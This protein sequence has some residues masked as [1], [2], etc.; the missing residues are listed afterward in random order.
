M[1]EDF[2]LP[3]VF[4]YLVL[5]L[6]RTL[7]LPPVNSPRPLSLSLILSFS[8]LLALSFSFSSLHQL[9]TVTNEKRATAKPV[10][11]A[12]AAEAAAPFFAPAPQSG[13]TTRAPSSAQPRANKQPRTPPATTCGQV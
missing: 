6:T 8:Q 11:Q 7:S 5:C 3:S 10:A 1:K 2:P 4:F 12:S 13:T 9:L